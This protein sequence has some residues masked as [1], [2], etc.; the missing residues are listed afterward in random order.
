LLTHYR[1]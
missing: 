1:C